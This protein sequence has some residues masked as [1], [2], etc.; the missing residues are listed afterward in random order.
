M[1]KAAE[2]QTLPAQQPKNLHTQRSANHQESSTT[3][4]ERAHA[5]L[6]A[7][8]PVFGGFFFRYRACTAISSLPWFGE[9]YREQ[10]PTTLFL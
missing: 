6:R 7:P 3:K 5:S 9:T 2:P 8:S 1:K 10:V 4:R